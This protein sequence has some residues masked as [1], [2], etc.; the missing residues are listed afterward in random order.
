[1]YWV[2]RGNNTVQYANRDGS[3]RGSWAI[4]TFGSGIAVDALNGHVYWSE[5]NGPG[6]VRRANLDGTGAIDIL[7]STVALDLALDVPGGKLYW[8][9]DDF[10]LSVSRIRRANLNGTGAET[11]VTV[12]GGTAF[13]SGIALDIPGN[14]VYWVEFLNGKVRRANLDGSGMQDLVTSG[15]SVVEIAVDTTNGKMYWG[16]CGGLPGIRRANLDGTSAEPVIPGASVGGLCASG[17][18]VD[19][20]GGKLYWADL[21]TPSIHRSNLD[22]TSGQ[23]LV[24]TTIESPNYLSLDVLPVVPTGTPAASTWGLIVLSLT[25]LVGG[26]CILRGWRPVGS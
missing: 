21:N 10:G 16:T 12:T 20:A 3:N 22:G 17:I 24:N 18:D 2:D 13:L 7:T 9:E 14:K 6:K 15:G 25:L 11:I 8:S 23:T 1:M 4:G 5:N 26:T 19:A